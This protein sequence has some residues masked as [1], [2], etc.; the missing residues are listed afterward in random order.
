LGTVPNTNPVQ[1]DSSGRAR[2]FLQSQAYTLKL[3]VHGST[4][5]CA[6]SLGPIIWSID[7]INPAANSILASNNTWTGIN[8]FNAATIF[9]GSTTFNAGLTS[10]GP[11]ILGGGGSMSGTY[12]GSP[13]FSGAPNFSGGFMAT[14]GSFSG[15]ITSTVLTGTPPF[16]ITSTT[17]I[18]NLNASLLL[19]CTWAIPKYVAPC[20]CPVTL[21]S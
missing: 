8:T 20:P 21:A 19:G 12:T 7:G 13:I 9:N 1:Y 3:Y 6:T 15:Q 18:P 10:T 4:N 5:N 2:V 14:T 11:N 17:N 16:V